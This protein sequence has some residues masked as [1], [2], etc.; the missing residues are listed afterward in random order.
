MR[1]S[2]LTIVIWTEKWRIKHFDKKS[3]FTIDHNGVISCCRHNHN[4]NRHLCAC[5][6]SFCSHFDEFGYCNFI[7]WNSLG[8]Q[9]IGSLAL[10]I[11]QIRSLILWTISSLHILHFNRRNE[12]CCMDRCYSVKLDDCRKGSF[13]FLELLWPEIGCPVWDLLA[14]SPMRLTQ[15]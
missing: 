11:E 7:N 13:N 10:K 3:F 12:G 4:G 5:N 1:P 8:S 6:C 9:S 14:V 2:N 15:N